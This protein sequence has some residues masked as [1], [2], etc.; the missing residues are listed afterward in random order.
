METSSRGRGGLQSQARGGEQRES[1][2]RE[3]AQRASCTDQAFRH[4]EPLLYWLG[5]KTG[6]AFS[7]LDAAA[8][9]ASTWSLTFHPLEQSEASRRGSFVSG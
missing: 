7:I 4:L 5:P 2:F 3:Q 9:N 1:G 6:C 8:M